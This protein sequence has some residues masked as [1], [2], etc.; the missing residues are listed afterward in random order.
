MVRTAARLA[1][2]AA[3]AILLSLAAPPPSVLRQAPAQGLESEGD[4]AIEEEY[5][6]E[7]TPTGDARVSDVLTY[8]ISDFDDYAEIFESYPNL[9]TRRYRGDTDVGEIEDFDVKVNAKKGTVTVTFFSPGYAYNMGDHWVVYGFPFEPSKTREGEMVFVGEGVMNNEFT[10]FEEI[11]YQI[12]SHVKLPDGATGV[13]YDHAKKTVT[14]QLPYTPAAPG[15]LLQ[16][17]RAT[18]LP[19]F[20]L[21]SVL[22]LL[23][24]A[25]LAFSSRRAP[26]YAATA[27]SPPTPPV[28]QAQQAPGQP[29]A[30][31]TF[32]PSAGHPRFCKNCGRAL[33]ESARSF[34]PGCGQPL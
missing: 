3:A 20:G 32:P 14:Y 27:T 11:E 26:Q 1:C 9:L 12:T 8:N 29:G 17:N 28:P 19:L 7:L 21:L 31:G 33:K 16:R 24:L 18:F 6:V 5:T 25:W 2:A 10:L 22:S 4:Y 34:C 13:K 30:V 15:N 23:L